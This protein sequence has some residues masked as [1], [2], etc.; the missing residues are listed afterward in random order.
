MD[1]VVKVI[2]RSKAYVPGSPEIPQTVEIVV[3]VGPHKG[4]KFE[5][6]TKHLR[7][8]DKR[9]VG[10]RWN[11]RTKRYDPIFYPLGILSDTGLKARLVA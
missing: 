9:Y 6:F 2:S 5:S 3:K 11:A 8:E 10:G 7:Y 4:G 1:A